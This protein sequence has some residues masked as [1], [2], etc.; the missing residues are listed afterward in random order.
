MTTIGI[1]QMSRAE[2]IKA[3]EGCIEAA[4]NDADF[5]FVGYWCDAEG[6]NYSFVGLDYPAVL[7]CAARLVHAINTYWDE[8]N[9]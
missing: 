2:H 8:T 3:M 5:K 4:K 6:G 7:G 1:R 9:D